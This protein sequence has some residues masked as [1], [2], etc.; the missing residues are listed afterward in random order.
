LTAPDLCRVETARAVARRFQVG[1]QHRLGQNFLVD[2]AVRQR[3]VAS[4]GPESGQLLEIGC[5][6]G[7][8]SQALLGKGLALT[9]LE[10]DPACVAALRLLQADHPEFRVVQMDALRA[11]PL[12]L[13]LSAPY[14]VIAN[15]PYQ[16]TGAILPLLL[17]WH[18]TP[19]ACHLVVQ[20]EVARRLAAPLGDWSL[21]TLSVRMAADVE[22]VFEI[23]PASFWPEPKVH[24]SFIVVRPRVG[25]ERLQQEGILDLARPIFQQRRKQLHHGLANSLGISPGRASQLLADAGIDPARRPGTLTPREWLDLWKAVSREPAG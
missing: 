14:S 16:I 23:P 3:I 18:P 20:R 15:L 24:S 13:G 21:A 22:S 2:D 10:F 19:V 1:P 17:R 5:G 25:P 12:E 8:L 9:G 7:A 4:L 11:D 6:L